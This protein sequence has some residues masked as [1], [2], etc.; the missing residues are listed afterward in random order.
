M[1][2]GGGKKSTGE[3]E[4]NS[5]HRSPF[6]VKY[7]IEFRFC[8][9]CRDRWGLKVMRWERG[10]SCALRLVFEV[11]LPME[12][13]L[14]RACCKILLAVARCHSRSPPQV[15]QRSAVAPWRRVAGA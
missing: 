15:C 4:N 9:S 12:V 1:G 10:V 8:C 13:G 5:I 14:D 3:C 11:S 7:R 2:S 6:S